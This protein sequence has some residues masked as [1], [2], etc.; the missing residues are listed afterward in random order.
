MHAIV[1]S[2]ISYVLSSGVERAMWGCSILHLAWHD[3]REDPSR[4]V[5]KCIVSQKLRVLREHM[6]KQVV[7]NTVVPRMRQV[8]FNIFHGRILWI[9]TTQTFSVEKVRK[10][11]SA[12]HHFSCKQDWQLSRMQSL[13]RHGFDKSW[14]VNTEADHHTNTCFK[15][16]A[17]RVWCLCVQL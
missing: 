5:A 8:G 17:C 7:T 12:I 15:D 3:V 2:P 9:L 11:T 1:S 16:G 14:D 6:E 13:G 10:P 4:L